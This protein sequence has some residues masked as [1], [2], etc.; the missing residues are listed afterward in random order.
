MW[1]HLH[2]AVDRWLFGPYSEHDSISGRLRRAL[3]YPYAIIRDLLGGQLSLHAM[4]LVYATLLAVIPLVAFSFALLKAFGAHRELEPLIF[5]F[6]RPMGSSA[7]EL[8]RKVMEFADKVRGGILG[9]VGLALL[10]WTLTDTMKKVENSFN[11]VWRVEKPRSFARR[12]A[13]YLSLL[14]IAPLMIGGII[15]LT[16]VAAKSAS[17]KLLSS[18][19]LLDTLWALV[20]LLAPIVLAAALLTILYRFIPNT[21]V[22]LKPAV[23]GGLAA[24]LLWATIGKIFATFVAASARLTIVYAG[25]AIIIAALIWT[26]LGWLILL[27]GAQVSFYVQNPSYLR[28]GLKPVHL[29]NAETE[30]LAVAMMYLVARSH[31]HGRER[32]DDDALALRLQ[33]PGIAVTRMARALE[34]AG[35]LASTDTQHLLPGRDPAHIG[36]GEILQVA[37]SHVDGALPNQA[38]A[39]ERVDAFLIGLEEAWRSHCNTRSL[40]DLLDDP[41]MPPTGSH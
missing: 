4:S 37:R 9:S 28:I 22:A 15:A 13:E 30:R 3:R 27:L 31:L 41:L 17:A 29:S 38:A 35:L 39:V 36:L 40:R 16:Q 11:F 8:T 32:W 18:L 23:A 33:V 7:G 20:L 6:F 19:P 1:P 26:Y 12:F 10:L 21:R 14:F 2:G 25:F 5:E 24:G 34:N